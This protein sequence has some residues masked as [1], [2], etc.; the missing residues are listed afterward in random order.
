MATHSTKGRISFSKHADYINSDLLYTLDSRSIDIDSCSLE[1]PELK[2]LNSHKNFDDQCLALD[3]L[4]IE[5]S[6]WA[7]YPVEIF[8]RLGLKQGMQL[9][10]S[11]KLPAAGGLSSSHA[12]MISC[13]KAY[14]EA[15]TLEEIKNAFNDPEAHPKKIFELIKLCQDVDNS[16]GFN[17][18]LGDQSAEIFCK[19]NHFV[20]VKLF[21][22]IKIEHIKIPDEL[23]IITIPSGVK[24]D[25]SLPEFNDANKNIAIYKTINDLV[26]DYGCNYLGDMVYQYNDEELFKFLNSIEDKRT[27][28][29]AL[30]GLAESSRLQD[31]KKNFSCE[32]L[33]E[34]LN[35]SHQA[36]K[37]KEDYQLNPDKAIKE[38]C[39][40]YSASTTI[41][42]RIQELAVSIEG[43]Y[44]CSISGAGLGGNNTL[45]YNKS[46]KAHV[47]R[48]L[49]DK[50]GDINGSNYHIN[51]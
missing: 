13:L 28:G 11:S 34:H 35:L 29:L 21:P 44:G 31:L 10:I 36:E 42:D 45:I 48:V 26:K 37:N 4:D 41:N 24:A 8:R 3:N 19:E 15:G 38:H 32:K 49:D 18:G 17:S 27:R 51:R 16:R 39:G 40:L 7:F 43:V 5:K 1:T 46:Q 25:K 23:G 6:N 20:F 22:E 33:G 14:A 30:Y 12:L 50:L 9:N 2:L 47:T